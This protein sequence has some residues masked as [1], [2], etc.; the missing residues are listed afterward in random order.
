VEVRESCRGGG[1]LDPQQIV[2]DLAIEAEVDEAQVGGC[3]TDTGEDTGEVES[4]EEQ[5]SLAIINFKLTWERG[6]RLQTGQCVRGETE[7]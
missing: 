6:R 5:P 4:V 7:T 3:A 1:R 2:S